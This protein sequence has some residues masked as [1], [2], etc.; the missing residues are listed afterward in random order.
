MLLC[1]AENEKDVPPP[2]WRVTGGDLIS[3]SSDARMGNSDDLDEA[4]RQGI[5]RVAGAIANLPPNLLDLI[6]GDQNR[7]LR[8]L[9]IT[10]KTPGPGLDISSKPLSTALEIAAESLF[11]NGDVSGA[12][13]AISSIAL[14]PLLSSDRAALARRLIGA[15]RFGAMFSNTGET[16]EVNAK[17]RD[18]A[19][20]LSEC[21]LAMA[22]GTKE[23][24]VAKAALLPERMRTLR[25]G[26][27]E[28]EVTATKAAI[29]GVIAYSMAYASSRYASIFLDNGVPDK[30]DDAQAIEQN[31]AIRMMMQ[32]SMGDM[33]GVLASVFTVICL[34]VA[35]GLFFLVFQLVEENFKDFESQ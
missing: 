5:H 6:S 2:P 21:A 19:A 22:M 10:L 32:S 9:C 15:S 4:A 28:V 34:V 24:N 29:G 16:E 30:F 3:E 17:L 35:T 25:F 20:A 12:S 23:V 26:S 27:F 7:D 14:P 8:D 18:L 31:A 13:V 11:E 1:R 33:A